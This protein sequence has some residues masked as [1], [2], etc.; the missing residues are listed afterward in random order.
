LPP[1]LSGLQRYA[2]ETAK[3]DIDY[4]IGKT[5]DEFQRVRNIQDTTTSILLLLRVPIAEMWK[6]AFLPS[7]CHNAAL[8]LIASTQ[9]R[10]PLIPLKLNRR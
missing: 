5:E 4:S 1:C 6:N 8:I 9:I 2:I 7:S 3:I 10:Q